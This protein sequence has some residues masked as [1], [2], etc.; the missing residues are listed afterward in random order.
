MFSLVKRKFLLKKNIKYFFSNKFFSVLIIT[1]KQKS[2]LS[3]VR[4]NVR[5]E[6]VLKK[7]D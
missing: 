3:E 2:A 4:I 5:R 1:E 6:Y 7:S